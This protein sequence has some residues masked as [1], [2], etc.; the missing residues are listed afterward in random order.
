MKL[1]VAAD[2][3]KETIVPICHPIGQITTYQFNRG[4][5]RVGRALRILVEVRVS[6][7]KP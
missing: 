7:V 4:K 3:M 2:K 1:T 6:R 5:I